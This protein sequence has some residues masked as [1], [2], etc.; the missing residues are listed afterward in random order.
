MGFERP[1]P[2]DS[3]AFCVYSSL[4]RKY[5]SVPAPHYRLAA[6]SLSIKGAKP[7]KKKKRKR[8]EDEID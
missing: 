4:T 1:I 6:R 7:N 3:F 8:P 5:V 2:A